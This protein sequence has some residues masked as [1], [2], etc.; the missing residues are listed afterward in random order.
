[1][2]A[3]WLLLLNAGNFQYQPAPPPL[4]VYGA[5]YVVHD[6]LHPYAHGWCHISPVPYMHT[7][8]NGA[9]LA[10]VLLLFT[11]TQR[12][13]TCRNRFHIL[14]ALHHHTAG[15]LC[16]R[17]AAQRGKMAGSSHLAHY[18]NTSTMYVSSRPSTK[19]FGTL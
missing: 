18:T 1:M 13:K 2:P 6:A 11:G 5:F 7:G 16:F 12:L 10:P 4:L 8:G 19:E 15:A 9:H 17:Q 14:P 3:A